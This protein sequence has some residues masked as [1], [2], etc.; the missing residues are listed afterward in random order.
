MGYEPPK[1]PRVF[2]HVGN[3]FVTE[4]ETESIPTSYADR[5]VVEIV[6]RTV[7]VGFGFKNRNQTNS[8]LK[9]DICQ[10]SVSLR[11]A[12]IPR[13]HVSKGSTTRPYT[14]EHETAFCDYYCSVV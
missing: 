5:Y 12:I 8:R 9:I 10:T 11:R 13:V 7:R 14:Y 6:P 2:C 1:P 4:C 3:L